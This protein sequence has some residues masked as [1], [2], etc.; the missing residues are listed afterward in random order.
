MRAIMYLKTCG[1]RNR[2]KLRVENTIRW[3]DHTDEEGITVKQSN[4]R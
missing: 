2:T 4:A 1:F 3:R